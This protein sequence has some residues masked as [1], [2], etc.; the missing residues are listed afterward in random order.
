MLLWS[1]DWELSGRLQHRRSYATFVLSDADGRNGCLS[2]LF[3]RFP[4]NLERIKSKHV[5]YHATILDP[6]RHNAFAEPASFARKTD[7]RHYFRVPFGALPSP[8]SLSAQFFFPVPIRDFENPQ[9]RK[10]KNYRVRARRTFKANET[11]PLISVRLKLVCKIKGSL[12][13]SIQIT[14]VL[15]NTRFFRNAGL[16]CYCTLSSSD[17]D[18]HRYGCLL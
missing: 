10:E 1:R 16:L 9:A 17:R 13:L 8:P 14:S 11:N 7:P 4:R 15:Q 18:W 2:R 3:C 6:R 5:P 12:Q